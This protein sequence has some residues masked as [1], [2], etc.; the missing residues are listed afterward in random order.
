MRLSVIIVS[1]NVYPFLDNC[2]RSVQQALDGIDGEIIVVDNASVDRTPQFIHDHFPSVKL[3]S[4]KENVGFAKANNQGLAIC[5]GEYVL[6]LNPDT[7]VSENTFSIC[8]DFMNKHP[9][10]GAIGVR[11]LDGSGRFLPESKRGLPTLRA[12][13][14]KMT[15]IYNLFPKS[16]FMNSY[17]KGN[18]GEME[19]SRIDV[20]C[21]AFMFIRRS[22]LDKTGPLDE[23]FFMYGEDIDLSYRI[24]KA[25]YSIYYLPTTNIIHYKGES[26]RKSSLNYILTFYQA[27]LI[28][29]NKHPQFSGQ[30]LLI[31]L[32]IYLHGFVQFIRQSA[33]SWWPPLMDAFLL[34]SSF[35]ITSYFWANYYYHHPEY[36]SASFYYL[37]VPLYTLIGVVALFLN[38]AYDKP[39]TTRSSWL[40]FGWAVLSILVIYAMLPVHMR[41][42]RM[43]IVMGSLIYMVLMILTRRKLPPWNSSHKKV[44]ASDERRAIIVGGPIESNR[45]KEL[46]N[47]SRDHIDIIGTVSPDGDPEKEQHTLG[48]LA[49]LSD[50]V[51][52]H[53]IKEIIFSAQDVPFSE[54]TSQMTTLGPSFRYML[55]ASSTMNIVGSMNRDTEGESYAIQVHFKLSRPASLRAKRIFDMISA[56]ILLLA[57]PVIYFFIQPNK[58]LLQN[59]LNVLRGHRTWISYDPSDQMISSLPH[60]KK[61]ILSP[62]YAGDALASSR[63]LEYIHYVYARD[64]HWTSDLSLLA[65]QLNK[66]GQKPL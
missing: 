15:G 51:R 54:F 24:T 21:G 19:T 55:A 13:F 49:Q 50:I 40:G 1:Y 57:S 14:M 46:I 60:I 32:A 45:I 25:G 59:I 41:T 7:V 44:T 16:S 12:T 66:I 6:L 30:K 56:G 5:R 61:G 38:G 31:K 35:Y 39:Y 20:L 2:L 43:V 37:N 22:T 3:I 17:Y 26:T 62:S 11:M 18:I 4:N 23:S 28:F 10:A 52:V 47:R 53:R 27:M 36:F 9:D 48:V 34:A 29:T 63:R 58:Y 64:Y 42:S 65:S 8:I 33:V